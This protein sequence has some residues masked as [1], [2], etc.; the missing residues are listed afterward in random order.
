MTERYRLS[1]WLLGNYKR[2]YNQ[3]KRGLSFKIFPPCSVLYSAC[4]RDT[5]G[6]SSRL[7]FV[8]VPTLDSLIIQAVYILRNTWAR[9]IMMFLIPMSFLFKLLHTMDL[10][11]RSMSDDNWMMVF[12]SLGIVI[13]QNN[14]WRWQVSF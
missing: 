5:E 6:F 11:V 13:S 4:T 10:D 9:M 8:F 12:H 7:E 1:G 3:D 14:V 2:N